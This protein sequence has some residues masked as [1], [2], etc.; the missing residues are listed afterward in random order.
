M[1]YRL[2]FFKNLLIF[3]KTVLNWLKELSLWHNIKFS[4]PFIFATWWWRPLIFDRTEFIIWNIY[5]IVIWV[6]NKDSFC[7]KVI[8]FP[9]HGYLNISMAIWLGMYLFFILERCLRIFM[10]ARSRRQGISF[11]HSHTHTNTK[12]TEEQESL[13]QLKVSSLHFEVGSRESC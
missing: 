13:V 2:S 7:S 12:P 10:D 11:N 4:N 6:C 1:N 9:H 3:V 8:F 5:G